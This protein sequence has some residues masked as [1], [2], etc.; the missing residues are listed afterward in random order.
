VSN[1][2]Q[3]RTKGG[4]RLTTQQQ[5]QTPTILIY[6]EFKSKAKK[7]KSNGKIQYKYI[8]LTITHKHFDR[9]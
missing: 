9:K 4:H 2:I 1:L 3:L 5:E 6:M 8:G 7:W